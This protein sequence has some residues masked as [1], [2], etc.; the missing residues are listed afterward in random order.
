M[1]WRQSKQVQQKW[2]QP[3]SPWMLSALQLRS[4]Q[5]GLRQPAPALR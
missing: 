3:H 5:R 2:V 1:T 4:T